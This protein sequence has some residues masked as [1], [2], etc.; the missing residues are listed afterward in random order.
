MFYAMA[1]KG[2]FL[3]V[4]GRCISVQVV[5]LIY[6]YFSDWFTQNVS[7]SGMGYLLLCVMCV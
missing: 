5:T 2:M 3:C 6:K 7:N 1:F 4:I